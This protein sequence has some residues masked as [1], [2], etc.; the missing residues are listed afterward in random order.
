M[1]S[2][3]SKQDVAGVKNRSARPQKHKVMIG[4]SLQRFISLICAT[5]RLDRV[6]DTQSHEGCL[7]WEWGGVA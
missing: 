5:E 2:S 6:A 1:E 7:G 4:E 3:G